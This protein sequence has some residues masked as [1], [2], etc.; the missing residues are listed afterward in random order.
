M[1][2]PELR[3]DAKIGR[4]TPPMINQPSVTWKLVARWRR[5]N[6]V[7]WEE[8]LSEWPTLTAARVQMS[9][10]YDRL[11]NSSVTLGDI[12]K[13]SERSLADLKATMR[14]KGL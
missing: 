9:E 8:T 14:K 5:E 4:P 11:G 1:S 2:N 3:I 6:E 12:I 10:T 7:Y 13:E